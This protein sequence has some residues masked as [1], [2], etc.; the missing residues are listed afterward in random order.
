MKLNKNVFLTQIKVAKKINVVFIC[1]KTSFCICIKSS[2]TFKGK[3]V[4]P[5]YV[6]TLSHFY[7]IFKVSR[8][9]F[10]SPPKIA[11]GLKDVIPHG[12]SGNG[13]LHDHCFQCAFMPL[14]V[15]GSYAPGLFKNSCFMFSP[16]LAH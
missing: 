1:K 4:L 6:S 15:T 2:S 9:F 12:A 10:F 8:L 7:D 13:D 3:G 14:D 5:S 16:P 11:A